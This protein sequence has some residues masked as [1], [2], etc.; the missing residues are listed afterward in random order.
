MCTNHYCAQIRSWSSPLATRGAMIMG[1]PWLYCHGTGW[2]RWIILIHPIQFIKL[3]LFITLHFHSSLMGYSGTPLVGLFGINAKGPKQSWIVVC[4][5]RHL[6]VASVDTPGHMRDH[7][8]FIFCTHVTCAPTVCAWN[9][10]S[11]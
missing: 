8:N 7:G 3:D 4:C 1:C 11:I 9:I 2:Q 5:R 10:K 6:T